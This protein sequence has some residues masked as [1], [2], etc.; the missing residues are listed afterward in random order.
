MIDLKFSKIL[1]TGGSGFIGSHLTEKLLEFENVSIT[2][3]DSQFSNNVLPKDIESQIDLKKLDI[4]NLDDMEGLFNEIQPELCFHLAAIHFIPYCMKNPNETIDTNIKGTANIQHLCSKYNCHLIQASSADVYRNDLNPHNEESII[5]TMN[6]YGYTKRVNEE[7]LNFFFGNYEEELL[8]VSVRIFNVYGSRDTQPHVITEIINQIRK[9]KKRENIN[10]ELGNIEP[11]RDFI[12]AG[13]VADGFISIA[14]N[15][16]SGIH[17]FN[18]GS[19]ESC[20]IKEIIGKIEEILHKKI[21][22]E[23]SEKRYR[24]SDRMNLQADIS[25]I[26]NQIDWQPAISIERGLQ[27][28]LKEE[29][30]I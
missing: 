18:L 20:S 21:N 5:E 12:Y 17:T 11:R 19:G 1:I 16:S 9:Q 24:K 2:I 26:R 28:L 15:I 23:T 22:V 25:K 13:D 10:L 14:N 4:R 29:L 3:V 7:T 8:G 30:G 6:I 27:L